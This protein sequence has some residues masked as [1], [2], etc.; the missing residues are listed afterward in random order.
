M[1]FTTGNIQIKSDHMNFIKYYIN[2][3]ICYPKYLSCK[4]C[5]NGALVKKI[6]VCNKEN[7]LK[8]IDKR[9]KM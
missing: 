3:W 6:S 1:R 8:K 7:F 5:R 2:K 9:E 4:S